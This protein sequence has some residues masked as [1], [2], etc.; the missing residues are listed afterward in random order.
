MGA[1]QLLPTPA[2]PRV[3]QTDRLQ[4]LAFALRAAQVRRPPLGRSRSRGDVL[5]SSP[6][7]GRETLAHHSFLTFLLSSFFF[8]HP[9]L[10]PSLSTARRPQ[11]SSLRR[12]RSPLAA[13]ELARD[14]PRP[15]PPPPYPSSPAA[16]SA[17]PTLGA[18]P[19]SPGRICSLACPPAETEAHGGVGYGGSRGRP[20]PAATPSARG[21]SFAAELRRAQDKE[22]RRA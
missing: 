11:A 8:P 22:Q 16:S 1:S 19:S 21:P 5:A 4:S 12:P 17:T 20:D 7:R 3:H 14:L 6:N 2:A 18:L 9:P 13:G 15:D 10:P